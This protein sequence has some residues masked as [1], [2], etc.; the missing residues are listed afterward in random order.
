MSE[1]DE[2]LDGAMVVASVS[3]GKDSTA[4]SLYLTEQGIEHRRVFADTG[5][6][7]E[8]T[9]DHV[10]YLETVLGPIDRVQSEVGGM[11][12]WIEKKGQF[13]SRRGR[14]C[15]EKLKVKPILKFVQRMQ[16]EH[17]EVVNAVGI[18][19]LESS[20]RAKMPEWE[21]S[22]AFDCWVWR[23]LIDWTEQDVVDMHSRHAVKPNRLYLEYNSVTRVGCWPCIFSRK[24][25]LATIAR[26]DPARLD[27]IE[28]LEGIVK[29]KAIERYAK[30]GE[31]L[32]SLGYNPPTFF[33]VIDPA[34][35]KS[36]N[37][38]V[39]IR[40]VAEWAQTSSGG[41]QREL[42]YDN[43]GGCVRWGLCET[44]S[45]PPPSSEADSTE[46]GGE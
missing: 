38:M 45:E 1:R 31:T 2:K 4:L 32:E 11:V 21:W 44:S 12:E 19:G 26:E 27:E 6:E 3:G 17:G 10:D 24:S 36:L 41:R 46:E 22:D 34:A 15:T 35:D 7:H 29:E 25:E 30:R 5:W 23:P 37:R 13:P 14:W 9:Y 20:A 33:N 42:F 8:W 18:R 39:P 28:R 40:E 43:S 16:D